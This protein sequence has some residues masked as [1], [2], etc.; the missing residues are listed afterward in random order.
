MLIH[1]LHYN[2]AYHFYLFVSYADYRA[3]TIGKLE[4]T[5]SSVVT[6]IINC[7]NH[8]WRHRNEHNKK[9]SCRRRTSYSHLV[10]ALRRGNVVRRIYEV[11]GVG[12][13][14]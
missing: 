10:V 9:L 13:D 5:K 6:G 3:C 8:K 11:T 7:L 4:C 1:V 2:G 14:S 12:V